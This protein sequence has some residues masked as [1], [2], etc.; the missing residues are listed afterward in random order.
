MS[1]LLLCLIITSEKVVELHYT[2]V[3]PH[4]D[5]SI[6]E[7][8]QQADSAYDFMQYQPND[9]VP[10]NEPTVAYFLADDENLY[11]AIRC[12]TPGREPVA[13]FKGLEDHIWIYLD[14]F[15]SKNKAYMFAVCLSGHYDDGMMLEDG[16]VQD[17]SWDYVWFFGVK[18]YDER[19]EIEM[20]IPFKSIRY[21]KGLDEWGLNIR[22]WHIK[23]YAVSNWITFLQQEGM[24]ISKFGTLK[25]VY[26]KSKGYYIE[27][28]PEGFFR[29]D[30][31]G[32]STDY[33]PS[34]SF[35]FKWDPTSQM[36]LNGTINPDF[37]HIESDPY[38]FN[39]SRY[40][41]RLEERRPFFIEGNEVFRMSHLGLPFFSSLDVFYTRRV[42]KPLPEGG[43]V[44]ILGGLKLINKERD[45]NFGVL[46]AYTDSVD[47]EPNRG[48]AV[49]R[50]NRSVFENS[51]IGMLFS[52]TATSRDDYNYAI[53]LDGA[54]RSGPSQFILQSAISDKNEKRGWAVSSGGVYRS[55]N[56]IAVGSVISV[57]D[58][59]D[60]WDMGYVPWQGM[61]DLY[62]A[63]GPAR[64][65]ETGPILRWYLEPG[66]VLTKYPE[67]DNWSKFGSVF[68]ESQFRNLWGFNI[69]AEAGQQYEADTNY[70]YRSIETAVWSGLRPS[71]NLHFGFNYAHCYNYWRGW[72]A[73][74]LWIWHW[75]SFVPTSRL[76]L[77]TYGDFV[78]EW[79]PEG[80]IGAITPI[81]T[82]RIEY[83]ISHNIDLSL[84]SEF[85]F[86]TEEG[87]L[88]TAE[89]ASNRIGFLFA[90]NFMPKSWFYVALNDYRVNSGDRLELQERIAAIKV[91]YLIYF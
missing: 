59:F 22:R 44:P 41:I 83:K 39:L 21:K 9:G 46:G 28:F 42:G 80:H 54:Y 47:E 24:Q 1:L 11:I 84:Y 90:W 51:E 2:E 26:P 58:S 30:Q 6:E 65:P 55:S 33:T 57:D 70:F 27:L 74:Q 20:R 63:A 53:G 14:T 19:Y 50:V 86:V 16:R 91:K 79:N 60:V 13:S 64:Y 32:D 85:V 89:I 12:Y 18:K 81:W 5:G 38:T 4:I 29:Y 34:L 66:I 62:V 3:A 67:S 43:S 8:W 36:T 88:R 31:I 75:M 25:N 48:F 10:T 40:P 72:I 56:F 61:T 71:M 76:S 73:S 69:Y 7:V 49:A 77:I 45:W 17:M 35:N 15:K 68:F 52:S 78:I 82:P 87:K 23:D 37:A